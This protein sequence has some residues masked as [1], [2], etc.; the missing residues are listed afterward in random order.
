MLYFIPTPIGNKE[1]ITLRALRLFKELKTFLCEDTRTAKKLF[2]M[3]EIDYKEKE[4]F[5]ITSFTDKGK[6]EHYKKLITKQEVGML[7]E[8]GTPGLSDPGK[9]LI[10]LCNEAALP[11]TILPGANALVPAIV[12]AGFDT[13]IF[14]FLGFLPQKKGRQTALKSMIHEE[15]PT[16]FYESVHRVEK[17]L[18][19]LKELGFKGEISIAREISKLFEQYFTG[20]LEEVEEL[21]KENKLA[22]KGEFVVGIKAKKDEK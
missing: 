17:L 22:I 5:A 14:S 21:I 4:F 3:Y 16:F 15:T 19:E 7:S 13:T 8:A 10:Q 11:Y 1:D 2:G 9:S 12:G 18:K 6:M 20:S